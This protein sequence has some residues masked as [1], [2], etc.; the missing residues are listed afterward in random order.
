MHVAAPVQRDGRLLG[1]LTVAKPNATVQPFIDRAE[2]K[3]LQAGALL[4]GASALVG[5][6]VTFWTV[7]SV[8]RRSGR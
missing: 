7:R 5:L 1:V 4:I 2:R 8:R 3:I 6:A